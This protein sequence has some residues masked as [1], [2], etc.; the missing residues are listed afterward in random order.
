MNMP[1]GLAPIALAALLVAPLGITARGVLEGMGA[2]R[3]YDVDYVPDGRSLLALSPSLR[4]T[5]ANAYWLATVQYLGEPR[6]R[7]RGFDK[8]FPL[9]DL[10]T[11]LDPRHGYA[12]HTAGIALSGEG[13]I[14]ESDRIMQ[15]GIEQGPNWW[16]YPWQI[17][18][19]HV[20]YRG[21][22]ET[23]AR[24]AEQAARTPGA[25]HRVA[26][27]AMTLKVRSGSAEEAVRFI[28][29]LQGLAQDE[30]TA[31]GLEE[32]YRLALHARNFARLDDAVA[33]FRAAHG[34]APARIEA[35]VDAGLVAAIP[36]DPFGGR[37]HVDANGEVRSTGPR[38]RFRPA[39][40]PRD[41]ITRRPILYWQP[42]DFTP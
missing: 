41:R 16:S 7:R 37:Y 1:R 15:K 25:S 30:V 23:A 3:P 40:A 10:V 42:P 27:L 5:I 21:D 19:N 29:E 2:D 12:Y 8:L 14:D 20:F 11:T 31:K 35:L 9:V 13:L 18:F 36:A 17:A 4:L 28:E 39:E 26:G 6:A 34:R 33:R 38:Q 32:Q 22:V 24:W